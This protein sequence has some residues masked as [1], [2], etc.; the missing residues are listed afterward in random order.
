MVS[1]CSFSR[2]AAGRSMFPPHSTHP[3]HLVCQLRE[4]DAYGYPP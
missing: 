3:F 4:L 1:H 2:F